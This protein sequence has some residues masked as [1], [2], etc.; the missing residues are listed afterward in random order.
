MR[1]LPL[2][3]LMCCRARSRSQPAKVY[4]AGENWFE[5]PGAHHKVNENASTTEPAQLLAVFVVDANDRALTTPDPDR[6][7]LSGLGGE[8]VR[9][10]ARVNLAAALARPGQSAVVDRQTH[11]GGPAFARARA[12]GDKPPP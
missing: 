5:Q 10:A 12:L 8:E 11:I 3:V 4:R 6:G 2:S 9:L 1:V 7:K